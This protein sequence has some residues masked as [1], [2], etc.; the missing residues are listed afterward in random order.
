MPLR[1]PKGKIRWDG[2]IE[3]EYWGIPQMDSGME[4]TNSPK[5]K[6]MVIRR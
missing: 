4:K 6:L 3:K 2:I 5:A 1:F